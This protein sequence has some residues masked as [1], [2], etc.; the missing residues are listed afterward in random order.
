MS[1]GPW[2]YKKDK[3]FEKWLEFFFKISEKYRTV[4]RKQKHEFSRCLFKAQ[5]GNKRLRCHQS[6]IKRFLV[7]LSTLHWKGNIYF[8]RSDTENKKT[9]KYFHFPENHQWIYYLEYLRQVRSQRLYVKQDL[10]TYFCQKFIC[11]TSEKT[12]WDNHLL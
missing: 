9:M 2:K 7:W 12:Y 8:F 4:V 3:K 1:F 10:K 6:E 5:K 11:N